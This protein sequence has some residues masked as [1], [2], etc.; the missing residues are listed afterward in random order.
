MFAGV[1]AG[2]A[3]GAAATLEIGGWETTIAG[4]QNG[5]PAGL[6]AVITTLTNSGKTRDGPRHTMLDSLLSRPAPEKGPSRGVYRRHCDSF[7]IFIRLQDF[8]A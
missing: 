1:G 5:F 6:D 2:T 4:Y 8:E 7:G 3:K